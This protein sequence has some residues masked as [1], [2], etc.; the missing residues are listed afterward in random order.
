MR[1]WQD[2]QALLLTSTPVWYFS[3]DVSLFYHLAMPLCI[4]VCSASLLCYCLD[5]ASYEP[6]SHRSSPP[7]DFGSLFQTRA[8]ESNLP[9]HSSSL[10]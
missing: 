9:T 2:R 1:S 8:T 6:T 10:P 3:D 7:H 5:H 4:A